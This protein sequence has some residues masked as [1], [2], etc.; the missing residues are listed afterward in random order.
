MGAYRVA[1][2]VGAGGRWVFP[3]AVEGRPDAG[4][5]P[6]ALA[7]S[8]APGFPSSAVACG[9]RTPGAGSLSS[10]VVTL[11]R[12]TTAGFGFLG[13]IREKVR[14]A[15]RAAGRP[16]LGRCRRASVAVT[17]AGAFDQEGALAQAGIGTLSGPGPLAKK[18]PA[19]KLQLA[20]GHGLG[21]GPGV[22]DESPGTTEP[23]GGDDY[24]NQTIS[25][26]FEVLKPLPQ[27][28][29]TGSRYQNW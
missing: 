7:G 3:W 21:R 9:I 22:G 19:R 6:F 4:S 23:S 15:S 8:S 20:G 25:R 1:W 27:G 14:R 29:P 24:G 2:G 17:G 13:W 10:Q 5:V 11:A 12:R 18:R 26:A 16:S 28:P